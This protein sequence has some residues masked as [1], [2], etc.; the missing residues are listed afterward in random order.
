MV[1]VW[2]ELVKPRITVASTVTTAVGYV[3]FRGQFDL[4]MLPVLG[5]ILLQACGAAA[6]NQVQDAVLDTRMGRTAGR[7]IPDGRIAP[8]TALLGSLALLVAG[9][10]LSWLAYGPAPAL[11][12][13]AAAAVYNGIYTPL[14]RVTPFAALPGALVGA[15]PPAA[16]WAAAGGHL[17]D[18]TIH[19]IAFFFFLW[20]M[21]HF[22]LLLLHY[23]KDYV[24]AGLP[25][26]FD[27]FDR[28]QIGQL[29][30]VWIAAV[31]VASILMPLFSLFEAALPRY[32]VA[33]AGLV[34][35]LRSLVLLRPQ[36]VAAAGQAV[37]APFGRV[38]KIRFMEINTF[39]LLVSAALV[40]DRLV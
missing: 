39:V 32:L 8:R 31:A 17:A 14:K 10:A 37:A 29:T 1:R 13:L 18:P 27:R 30:F 2:L 9:T 11:L 15:L 5:G 19:Q 24:A 20:Q 25:S 35:V 33:A 36:A 21:P 40:A 4:A 22:W 3:V 23:E 34:V 38:Y 26:L 28:R 6:L 7:P 16:G 12:G